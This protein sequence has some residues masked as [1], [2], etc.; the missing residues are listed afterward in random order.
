MILV[1]RLLLILAAYAAAVLFAAV[2]AG[3]YFRYFKEPVGRESLAEYIAIAA[4]LAAL[5]CSVPALVVVAISEFV[6]LSN[7][8]FYTVSGAAIGVAILVVLFGPGFYG[9]DVVT[10]LVGLATGAVAGFIYW[11]IAGRSAGAFKIRK[12]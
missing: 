7:W 1:R 12:T 9:A 8:P 2:I 4:Y 5:L 11:L 6:P 3:V 10:F